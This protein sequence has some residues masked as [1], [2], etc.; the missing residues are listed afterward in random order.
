MRQRGYLV[1]A[2]PL[3]YE[4]GTGMTVLKL[5]DDRFTDT[6]A[7]PPPTRASFKGSSPSTSAPGM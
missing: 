1:A 4:A 3:G 6:T 2:G 7:W 5:P